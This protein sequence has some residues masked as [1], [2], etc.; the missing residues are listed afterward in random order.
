MRFYP[1]GRELPLLNTSRD[2]EQWIQ[3]LRA[4]SES[5]LTDLR[6]AL[7]LNLRKALSDRSRLDDSFLEDVA[8]DSLLRILDKLDQFAGRSR[9]L[10]WATTVAIRVAMDQLRRSR[11]KDVSLD[12]VIS[13]ADFVP[14]RAIDTS[15]SPHAQVERRAMLDAMKHAIQ[16]ALTDRQR[17]ALLAEMSGMPQDE[18][19][20]HLGSNRNAVYKLTHDARKKLKQRLEVEGYAAE[21]VVQAA[22]Q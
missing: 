2:N 19:A 7:L 15:L 9:F 16:N 1:S 11:W 5:A 13:E 22:N 21:D 4:D 20:R 17:T 18:I 3:E 12:V 8:Q 6:N 10:T 14:E